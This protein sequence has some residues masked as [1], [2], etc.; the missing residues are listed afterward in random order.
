MGG[1]S[2]D[3]LYGSGNHLDTEVG[4]GLPLVARFVGTPRFGVR[5][6]EFGQDYRVG[7]GVDVLE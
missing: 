5:T 1:M 4:Y 3:A 2:H 7:Y 6:S